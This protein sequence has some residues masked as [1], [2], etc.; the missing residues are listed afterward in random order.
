MKWY[1]VKT[2]EDIE[3]LLTAYG[4]FE[5]STLVGYQFDSGNYVDEDRVSYEVNTNQLCLLFQR[6]D[7]NPFSIELVFEYTKRF[8]FFAPVGADISWR[9]EI[10]FAK[11]VKDDNWFYWTTWKEFD[12]YQPEHLSYN[13]FMLIQAKDLKWRIVE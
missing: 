7:D 9:S 1:P 5:D 6:L 13:D 10:L 12:P 11:I 3:K 8:N 4:H 2:S